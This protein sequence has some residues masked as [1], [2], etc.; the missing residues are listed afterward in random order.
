MK[1]P[2]APANPTA[3]DRLIGLL[4]ILCWMMGDGCTAFAGPLGGLVHSRLDR[5]RLRFESLIAR[6]RAGKTARICASRAGAPPREATA[7]RIRL[8]WQ[9]GWLVNPLPFNLLVHVGGGAIKGMLRVVLADPETIALI[10]SDKRFGRLMR[11]LCWMLGIADPDRPFLLR[12]EIP[13]PVRTRTARPR[14]ARPCAATPDA[15]LSPSRRWPL[16]P[17]DTPIAL[18]YVTVPGVGPKTRG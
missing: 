11:P 3:A 12:H 2:S 6:V 16:P 9:C 10:G 7:E 8:P 1:E 13:R 17:R 4:N 14:R 18:R 5:L 15:E